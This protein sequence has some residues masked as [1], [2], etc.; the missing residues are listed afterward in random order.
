M[1]GSFQVLSP[2]EIASA[3]VTKNQP[4][5]HR[6]HGVPYQARNGERHLEPPELLPS[7]QVEAVRGFL[8]IGRDGL[9]RLVH[10][11]RHVPRL[12]GEDRENRREF[13]PQHFSGE[14]VHEEHDGKRQEPEDRHRL[15]DVEDRDQDQPGPPAFCRGG[16]VGEGEQQRSDQ[17]REHPQRG[18][19]RVDRQFHR[20]EADRRRGRPVDR[21]QRAARHV[22]HA[23][24]RAEHADHR[25]QV[26]LVRQPP[27][28]RQRGMQ[29]A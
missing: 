10:A 9:Q 13:Q 8:E 6:H 19:Y 1:P 11:E 3:A 7:G 24:Q 4:P 17:R 16:G 20:V 21:H 15:Q 29:C 26:P 28:Q 22:R 27:A 2:T 5:R 18:A 25:K 12:A 23:D 14:Q